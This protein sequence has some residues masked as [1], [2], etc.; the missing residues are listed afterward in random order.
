YLVGGTGHDKALFAQC[1]F[2]I[3]TDIDNQRYILY[4]PGRKQKS[5]GYFPVPEVFSKRKEDAE[6]FAYCMKKYIGNYQVVYTRN[7]EGRKIL[8]KGRVYVMANKQNRAIQ[9]KRVKSALE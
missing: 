4:A 3:F 7:P 6:L 1:M 8:L 9:R 5:D 2:E